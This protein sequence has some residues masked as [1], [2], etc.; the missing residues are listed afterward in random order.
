MSL[1]TRLILKLTALIL[2]LNVFFQINAQQS[3]TLFFMHSLPQSNETNPAVQIPCKVFVG[4]PALSSIHL[5]FS[6]TYFSYGDLIKSA[7]NDSF[8]VDYNYLLSKPGTKQNLA[9]EF[10]INLINFG[11]IYKD[12]YFNFN[13]AD[14]FDAA[15]AYP[16]NWF[17]LLNGNTSHV[18]R[19]FD[20]GSSGAFA[21][22]YREWAF[23]VSKIMNEDLTLGVKAKLLFG[24]ANLNTDKTILNLY[25]SS[26][27]LFLTATSN[28]TGN[29][30]PVQAILNDSGFIDR[31]EK[32]NGVKPLDLILNKK[33]KGFALDFGAIYK[34]NDD[35]ELSGSLIDVGFIRWTYYTVNAEES[36]RFTYKGFDGS[37][38]SAVANSLNQIGDTFRHSF[39]FN[40]SNNSYTTFLSP[41]LYLGGTYSLTNSINAGLLFRNQLYYGKLLSSVTTSVNA[42]YK[43]YLA[44][45]LS[46]SYLNSSFTNLGAG[47]SM[48]TPNFGFYAVS[49]NFLAPIKWKSARLLNLR[50]G[51]NL[52][53]GCRSCKPKEKSID[54][55]GCAVYRDTEKKSAN[56][57]DWKER[58]I[59]EKKK[60]K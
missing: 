30:S 52:L 41:K 39:K 2:L 4:V 57:E 60:R 11:F 24:K 43:K 28:L 31:F 3:S 58:R 10:Q 50:F 27:S 45:S 23:G 32:P 55:T 46:W 6:S 5:N 25:T 21:T 1:F 47:V 53:F 9:F 15:V 48:R 34:L 20:L 51:F 33:N 35:I 8:I 36:N 12:Y 56:F 38:D 19:V 29:L 16:V 59:K 49:D 14:K 13:L 22:Y 17:V 54:N 37:I 40:S 42:W 44:L 7:P 18:G 26:D